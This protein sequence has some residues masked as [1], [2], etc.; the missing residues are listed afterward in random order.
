MKQLQEAAKNTLEHLKQLQVENRRWIGE[1]SPSALSTA[2]A[3]CALAIVDAKQHSASIARG[4]QWLANNVNE[5]G[6]WGDTPLSLSNISTTCLVWAA[7]CAAKQEENYPELMANAEKWITHHA[8]GI[9]M[10]NIATAIR[11]K[12][13]KDKTFAIPILTMCTLSG[14]FGKDR[15]LWRRIMQ[16]PF[17]LAA[18]PHQFF[19]FLQLPVVS[20]ALPALIAIGQVRHHLC[21]TRNPITY[22]LRRLTVNKTLSKLRDIQPT[23]GGYLEA[24]PLTSFVAMSLA[25]YLSPKHPGYKVVEEGVRFLVESLREDG[26]WPID[27]NLTVWGTTLTINA[28]AISHESFADFP[29]KDNTLEWILQLQQKNIHPFTNALPGGWAWIDLS[30]GVPD[31]DDTPGALIALANLAPENKQVISAAQ[32]GVVWLLDLQN[33][34]GGIPTFCRG[35]GALPFDRSTPDLT[36]HTLSAWSKWYPHVDNAVQKRIQI[37]MKKALRYLE[38]NWRNGWIPLWFGNEHAPRQE[39]PVYGTARVLIAL[40]DVK[41]YNVDKL[42]AQAKDYLLRAQNANG[43]WG[44]DCEV[45]P[46]IE[47]TALALHALAKLG[48]IS[49][50]NETQKAIRDG[51]AW[52]LQATKNGTHFPVTPIGL[53]YASLWYYELLYPIVFSLGAWQQIREYRKAKH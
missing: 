28:A 30:G 42:I 29:N 21:A 35:W 51:E 7:F 19:S 22:V 45:V 2:T 4:A 6:G 39:N 31:A 14:R 12:Y 40:L 18:L 8:G 38:K 9:S 34:D 44:G 46:S 13:G 32:N 36:A 20:Y 23:T 26:S 37:A 17:E 52:L 24:I 47:E 1:L 33:R 48:C 25:S 53:Y 5:D 15:K 11:K 27:I 3:I 41:I 16:L 49:S 50:D 43:G 10:E